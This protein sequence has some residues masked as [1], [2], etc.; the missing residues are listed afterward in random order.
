MY[1][2]KYVCINT[3]ELLI[4]SLACLW[5]ALASARNKFYVVTS[6]RLRVVASFGGRQKRG[7]IAAPAIFFSHK[8][9]TTRSWGCLVYTE[10]GLE[11]GV[12]P[13]LRARTRARSRARTRQY[14]AFPTISTKLLSMVNNRSLVFRSMNGNFSYLP[15]VGPKEHLLSPFNVCKQIHHKLPVF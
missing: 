11:P 1:I 9:E 2:C 7:H 14:F 5:V 15:L 13:G 12:A 10:P 8:S 4:A 3:L 6:I